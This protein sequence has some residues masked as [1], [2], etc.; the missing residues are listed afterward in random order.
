[1]PKKAKT[2]NRMKENVQEDIRTNAEIIQ[3][4][5]S[6]YQEEVNEV[7]LSAGRIYD[8]LKD[9]DVESD[10]ILRKLKQ[11]SHNSISS[12]RWYNKQDIIFMLSEICSLK[13]EVK[14]E[15]GK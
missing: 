14:S 4:K 3:Q 11:I 8:I 10:D 2:G 7:W 12:C 6:R 5:V 13:V 9:E 1:M 15:E